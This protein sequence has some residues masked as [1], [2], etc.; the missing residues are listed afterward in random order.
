MSYQIFLHP[1]ADKTL[2]S[3]E[4]QLQKRIKQ[5]IRTLK[6]GINSG[7]PIEG[8]KFFSLR[9]GDYRVIYEIKTEQFRIIILF[10]GHRSVVYDKFLRWLS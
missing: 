6:D 2:N 4:K 10:I 1:K 7:K 3:Y 8:T 5:T 9:V